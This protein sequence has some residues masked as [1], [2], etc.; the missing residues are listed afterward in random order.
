MLELVQAAD[1]TDPSIVV[2]TH[3]AGQHDVTQLLL[4]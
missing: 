2:R 4:A 3:A 1:L